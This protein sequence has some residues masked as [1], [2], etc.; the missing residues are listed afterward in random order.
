MKSLAD[1]IRAERIRTRFTRE[2][3][4]NILAI[5]L[6]TYIG[7]ENGTTKKPPESLLEDL[8]NF[9]NLRRAHWD[10]KEHDPAS[11]VLFKKE[12]NGKKED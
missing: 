11:L 8:T 5:S 7:Y 4:S 3:L 10:E 12:K 2:Q 1:K 6:E 9:Y